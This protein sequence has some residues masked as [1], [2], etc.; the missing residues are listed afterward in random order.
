MRINNYI[1][2][3]A[4]PERYLYLKKKDL[5]KLKNMGCFFQLNLLSLIGYYGDHVLVRS[6]NLLKNNIIDFTGSD[7][8]N[9]RQLELFSKKIKLDNCKNIEYL[10]SRNNDFY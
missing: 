3:I 9:E 7:I 6:K 4:H 8:H 2:I 5:F 10:C 1:P